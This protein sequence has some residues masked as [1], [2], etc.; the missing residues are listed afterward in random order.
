MKLSIG[1]INIRGL[2]PAKWDTLLSLLKPLPSTSDSLAI[3]DS[4]SRPLYDIIFVSETWYIDQDKHI[5]HPRCYASTKNDHLYLKGRQHGGL[6]VLVSKHLIASLYNLRIGQNYI[7]F[8]IGSKVITGIYLQ[9]SLSDNQVR[10]IMNEISLSDLLIG[11]INVRYGVS[12]GDT[13]STA[14]SR[15]AIIENVAA[16]RHWTHA[17]P[18]V[19][20][21]TVNH[22]YYS[23]LTNFL[24]EVLDYQLYTDH[25]FIRVSFDLD[26]ATARTTTTR[27][28]YSKYLDNDITA[29][30]LCRLF[31]RSLLLPVFETILACSST[32]EHPQ[33]YIDSLDSLLLSHCLLVAD[34]TIGSYC[35]SDMQSCNDTMVTSLPDSPDNAIRLFKRSLRARNVTCKLKSRYDNIPTIDDTCNFYSSIYDFDYCH[36]DSMPVQYTVDDSLY[37]LFTPSNIH[38]AIKDYPNAK[39]PGIDSVDVPLLKCLASKSKLFLELLRILFQVCVVTGLTPTRWNESII[40]PI[41]KDTKGP[42]TVAESRPISLTVMFRRIFEKVILDGITLLDQFKH[43]R[44]FDRGQA[45]FRRGFSTL[46]HTLL[47]HQGYNNFLIKIFIDL[48][49]AYDRV[50]I[51]LLLSKLANQGASPSIVSIIRSLF[52]NCS[53]RI[54]V[55]GTLSQSFPRKRGLFQGSI[56]SPWLF[57]VFI[58]DLSVRLNTGPLVTCLLFADDIQIQAESID[59]AQN[60]LNILTEWTYDNF[61]EINFAKCGV[62]SLQLSPLLLCHQAIPQVE[63]YNYLGFPHTV[64]G[65][66]WKSHVLSKVKKAA[67]LLTALKLSYSFTVWPEWAKLYGYKVFIRPIIEYGAPI[68]YSTFECWKK[69]RRKLFTLD[70]GFSFDTITDMSLLWKS[71]EN[72]Q[73]LSLAWVFGASKANNTILRSICALGSIKSH[74]I[75]L[76]CRFSIHLQSVDISNPITTFK[77]SPANTLSKLCFTALVRSPYANI[78]S[79]RLLDQYFLLN[80]LKDFPKKQVLPGYI[81]PSSRRPRTGIDNILYIADRNLRTLAIKWRRNNLGI[82]FT[83]TVC[84]TA[85]TRGHLFTCFY[86]LFPS[87]CYP[88]HLT[89]ITNSNNYTYLDYLLNTQSYEEFFFY[90]QKISIQLIPIRSYLRST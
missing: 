78:I 27:R 8:T 57:N 69:R 16:M 9:P 71:L 67:N 86:Y 33:E 34:D 46:T 72:M 37:A 70:T 74:F 65:I 28:F 53:S 25:M 42:Y 41:P 83:C 45:G 59:A 76:S 2:T 48:K 39:S 73:S 90:W 20:F 5:I 21:S 75:E 50:P 55:D 6:L 31:D 66:D 38:K 87:L 88:L 23:S 60:M 54:A 36:V 89:P 26:T 40:C 51:H 18:S 81:L 58:D 80:R 29:S 24:F 13:V 30:A 85:F 22:V 62:L 14:P 7:S 47:S 32:L 4:V 64:N 44:S 3:Y 52:T 61:M 79:P 1:F 49:Q 56:L 68:I 63:V 17:C 11:D 77:D 19:G 35:V 10:L 12:Y 84:F 82:N 15:K 43:L